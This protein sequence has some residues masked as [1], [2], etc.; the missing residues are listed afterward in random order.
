MD[1][2][3]DEFN[4]SRLAILCVD[5]DVSIVSCLSDQLSYS[6][7][8]DITIEVATSGQEALQI[9]SI[10]K[11]EGTELA[12]ILSDQQMSGMTGDQLLQ[13]VYQ[14]SPNT[15]AILLTGTQPVD[16][17][18]R[19]SNQVN[20]YRYI[21]K[22]WNELDLL[23]TVKEAIRRYRQDESIAD[24]QQRLQSANAKLASS[25]SL[26]LATLEAAADGILVINNQDQ[27]THVNQKFLDLLEV[28]EF[29]LLKNR[30]PLFLEMI[31]EYVATIQGPWQQI[32]SLTEINLAGE[33]LSLKLPDGR[34]F[35]CHGQLQSLDQQ[36]VGRVW[37][38][39]D[40]TERQRASELIHYQ[41]HYDALTGLVN[42][43]QFMNQVDDLLLTA[44]PGQQIA[45]MFLDLDHFKMV[46]DT[47][48]HSIGDCLLQRVV[49]RLQDCCCSGEIISRWGGDE[50]TI[51][52]SEIYDVSDV[53]MFAQSLLD[54]F[55]SSFDVDGH[56]IRTTI[57]IGISLF[58]NDGDTAETLLKYADAALYKAKEN[59]KNTYRYYTTE[60]SAQTHE[61]LRLDAAMY[62][63]LESEDFVLN[64]QPQIDIETGK[65]THLEVLL[66][67]DHPLM[68]CISPTIFIPIA[69]QNGL[70]SP[71]G[72]WVF[73]T[74]LKQ[75]S[76][77]HRQGFLSL[78]L[79]I[80]L[81]PLQ[82]QDPDLMSVLQRYLTETE[83]EPES[84]ELEVTETAMV[85]DFD[86]ARRL[87]TQLRSLGVNIALDDFGTG[88]ASLSYLHQL[89]FNT[90]KI[91]RSFVSDNSNNVHLPAHSKSIIEAV[92]AMGRGLDLRIVA[93]GVETK[94]QQQQLRDLGCRYMQ[95]YYLG[96]PLPASQISVLLQSA[97]FLSE[98]R[99]L[100]SLSC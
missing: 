37:S 79:A 64:Y 88:Y 26:L 91:D 23:L 59:G 96:R 71:L 100:N 57:S 5:D 60:L 36:V 35:E 34:L 89:P 80:N 83:I 32:I 20:L 49:K 41:A 46:N 54:R 28:P 13:Q 52:K 98:N 95:G 62:E 17:L 68:G 87:L 61:R 25:V 67:W 2:F 56:S 31:R 70:M 42:R 16:V 85:Q 78:K 66:R 99:I 50:F 29:I 7:D 77:W 10:L 53:V 90:L 24:Q 84:L 1:V 74:A 38:I 6:L 43:T 55:Q 94:N 65:I 63:S 72:N 27:I 14:Q 22:P 69:E 76:Q 73:K 33:W 8:P 4:P 58:P 21:P 81:S 86:S 18:T 75:L 97:G 82:M 51:V 48:G 44:K 39:R 3:V 11:S 47:L 30:S 40:V 92:I 45:V 15:L 12:L 9:L 19:A 93:E